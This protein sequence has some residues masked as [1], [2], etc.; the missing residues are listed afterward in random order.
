[1]KNTISFT[2]ALPA[3]CIFFVLAL[4]A[5]SFPARSH[6]WG[7]SWPELAIKDPHEASFYSKGIICINAK[8]GQT[9]Y[10]KDPHGKYYPASTTKL[11]TALVAV[12][13]IEDFSK[14]ATVSEEAVYGIDPES[15]HIALRVGEKIS[16]DDVMYGMLLMSGN[17]CAVVIAEEV[18]GSVESFAE[19]MNEKAQ[20]LGCTDSHF[21]NPH[22]T[23]D[24]DHYTSPA[25]MA[26]IIM[27]CSENKALVKYSS[28]LHHIIPKT[29][30]SDERR[31][32]WNNHKCKENMSHYYEPVVFG[33][34][35][36]VTRSKFNLA[37][38][39]EKDGMELITVCMRGDRAGYVAKDTIALMQYYFDNCIEI[40]PDMS[41]SEE[42]EIDIPGS[43]E[44]KVKLAGEPSFIVPDTVSESDV[45]YE[46]VPYD[47]LDFPVKK[48]T[49][50]G[51][52]RAVI[53]GHE[54]GAVPLVAQED[55]T[56]TLTKVV[57][58]MIIVLAVL[59]LLFVIV[60]WNRR[61][62]RINRKRRSRRRR[63]T[64]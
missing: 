63:S 61:R 20:E 22:G 49:F 16:L 53:D 36:Y 48:G 15:S 55:M 59:I 30:K 17:D 19:M 44:A 3:A 41:T 32:M 9:L 31:H 28:T 35:G 18:A 45:E 42:Y 29:N 60:L 47:D 7:D 62:M 43:G 40:Y 64:S 57:K 14:T 50:V 24:K 54:V 58:G 6:A 37:T 46:T 52:L 23:Y 11:L 33:K 21:V 38:Y 25:D 34:S 10:S 5:F 2:R 4:L 39:A 1:M 27:A 56:S 12:E 13:N 51:E 26:K 8:T